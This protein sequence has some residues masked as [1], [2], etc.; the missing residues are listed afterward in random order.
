MAD[1]GCNHTLGA[2]GEP[3]EAE[4]E[5]EQ[6]DRCRPDVR[7]HPGEQ[8]R[9]RIDRLGVRLVDAVAQ[10]LAEQHLTGKQDQEK[11]S[12]RDAVEDEGKSFGDAARIGG[13]LQL[14]EAQGEE[15]AGGDDDGAGGSALGRPGL[16]D[17]A[18]VQFLDDRCGD[19]GQHD[20][21]DE[22]RRWPLG[23]F[24]EHV[25]LGEPGANRDIDRDHQHVENEHGGTEPEPGEDGEDDMSRGVG[26]ADTELIELGAARSEEQTQG[27]DE[28][29]GK[30]DGR[31]PQFDSSPIR[32]VHHLALLGRQ[33][34]FVTVVP[35]EQATLY[36]NPLGEHRN[37][38]ERE[39]ESERDLEAG[40]GH[41][42]VTLRRQQR[43][44]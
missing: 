12:G 30:S 21:Q 19:H 25:H 37:E 23:Q 5:R 11:E 43:F 7:V 14:I 33:A 36:E 34:D 22:I 26:G 35:G 6:R 16:E 1:D 27:Q 3:A 38:D 24:R 31:P 42:A 39:E 32:G 40:P 15:D 4:A 2:I 9:R 17:T 28:L 10:Q 18:E 20:H 8:Q 44:E 13:E 29:P 41:G